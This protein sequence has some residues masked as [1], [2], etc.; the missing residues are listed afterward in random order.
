MATLRSRL[1]RAALAATL[2]ASIS[3]IAVATYREAVKRAEP[4]GD[5]VPSEEEWLRHLSSTYADRWS[6]PVG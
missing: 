5:R 1:S 3:L 2:A 6:G 4:R